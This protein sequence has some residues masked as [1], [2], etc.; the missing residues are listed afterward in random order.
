LK[1]LENL[2]IKFKERLILDL[3]HENKCIEKQKI[4]FEGSKEALQYA[5]RGNLMIKFDKPANFKS[6]LIELDIS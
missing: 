6:C 4:K 2:I 3:R 5:K 1:C